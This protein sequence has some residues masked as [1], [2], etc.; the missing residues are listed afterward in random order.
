MYGR[1][2][3]DKVVSLAKSMWNKV[4]GTFTSMKNGVSNLT[5][6]AR[7]S[8][9]NHWKKMKSSVTGLAS[10][11]W[12]KVKGTFS[13]MSNGIRNFSGKIKGHINSMVSGI[14]RFK[15]TYRRR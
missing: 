10:G 6:K 3:K 4:K 8:V 7:N 9:V 14:K 2:S 1:K 11:M 12:S 13:N 5:S 15:Q